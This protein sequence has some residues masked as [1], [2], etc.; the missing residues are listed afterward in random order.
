[1]WDP[2]VTVGDIPHAPAV[3]P[4]PWTGAALGICGPAI[5]LPTPQAGRLILLAHAPR[6]NIHVSNGTETLVGR[7]AKAGREGSSLGRFFFFFFG[8]EWAGL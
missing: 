5:T 8:Q 6:D 1:M 7:W 4:H 3:T 2:P